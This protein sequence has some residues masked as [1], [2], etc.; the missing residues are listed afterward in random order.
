MIELKQSRTERTVD[1][2]L[3]NG[4]RVQRTSGGID[5]YYN[6]NGRG[7]GVP[8]WR[9]CVIAWNQYLA[10]EFGPYTIQAP[11]TAD[12]SMV[13]RNVRSD[14]K[15]HFN[16]AFQSAA[17]GALSVTGVIEG[18]RVVYADAFGLGSDLILELRASGVARL[19]RVR[20]GFSPQAAYTFRFACDKL[21]KVIRLSKS[22][23]EIDMRGP[24]KVDTHAP[25]LLDTGDAATF[26]RPFFAWDGERTG[27]IPV[28]I[29]RMAY[30]F[31]IVKTAPAWWNGTTDLWMDDTSTVEPST[32]D[33]TV[34]KLVNGTNTLGNW[35]S[36][37]GAATGDGVNPSG[38][39]LLNVCAYYRTAST[40]GMRF[41]RSFLD[42]TPALA[43]G[44]TV[45]DVT[46]NLYEFASMTIA[47][48]MVIVPGAQTIPIV[49]GDY[50]A[51]TATEY[52]RRA[53]SSSEATGYKTWTLNAT[54]LAAFNK[55]AINKYAFIMGDD[56]DNTYPCGSQSTAA[57]WQFNS[58]DAASNKPYF[59]ITYTPAT[60]GV[61]KGS[62]G[63]LAAI[64]SLGALAL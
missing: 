30:G 52:S 46:C 35:N 27:V 24:K 44:D 60:T 23:Y 10:C 43:A 13:F 38:T 19:V 63:Q 45:T 59:D 47:D 2:D 28:D 34:Y 53:F 39:T 18:D 9:K 40:A 14:G 54:G 21:S 16:A 25:T 5:H 36:A 50:D 62:L 20:A 32:E 8:G 33:G 48:D 22:P 11:A 55:A 58:M 17:L 51:F 29:T 64:K 37:R 49:S 42:V 61:P 12:G 3:G 56:F 41:Q 7:D 26:I 6:H 57:A 31:D 4:H 1:Y 15:A